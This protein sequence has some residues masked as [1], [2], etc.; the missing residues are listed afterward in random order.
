RLESLFHPQV[1]QQLSRGNDPTMYNLETR[2]LGHQLDFCPPHRAD[3]HQTFLPT[4]EAH[5][6]A[7]AEQPRIAHDGTCLFQDLSAQSLLPRLIRLGTAAWPAPSLT[8]V[9]DQHD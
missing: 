7:E 4:R 9:A 2:F 6:T 8:I 3:Q 5:G 1:R